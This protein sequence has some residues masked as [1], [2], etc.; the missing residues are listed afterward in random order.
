MGLGP[1]FKHRHKPALA[2]DT[3]AVA[4]ANSAA[5]CGYTLTVE[6]SSNVHFYSLIEN[7][8]EAEKI[9]YPAPNSY[10]N[11]YVCKYENTN[12]VCH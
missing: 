4:V 9:S 8:P 2:A 1:I 3:A 6:I 5:R 11:S 12:F 10:R 7:L